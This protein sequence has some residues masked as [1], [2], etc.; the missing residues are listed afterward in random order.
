MTDHLSRIGLSFEDTANSA[1]SVGGSTFAG[2]LLFGPL[3][4]AAGG[5]LGGLV[6]YARH[7]YK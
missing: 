7:K 2:G 3:G 4:M 1:L 6:E 5:A